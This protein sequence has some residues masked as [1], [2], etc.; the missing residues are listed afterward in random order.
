VAKHPSLV[1]RL[2]LQ[3]SA[4]QTLTSNVWVNISPRHRP[5]GR[6]TTSYWTRALPWPWTSPKPNA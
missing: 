4:N 5:I 6:S 2:P 1:S 3:F